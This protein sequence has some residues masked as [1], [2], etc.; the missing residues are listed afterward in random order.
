MT[1]FSRSRIDQTTGSGETVTAVAPVIVSASR[2]T[3]IPAFHAEWFMDRL[4]AGY[5]VW[6]NPFNQ[7]PQYVSFANTRVIV[8]WTK[9]PAPLLPYLPRIE[10]LGLNSYFQY[11]VNDYESEGWEP[12]VPSLAKRLDTFAELSERIGPERVIWRFDPLLLTDRVTEQVLA[13]KVARVGERLAPLTSKLVFS[14][15]DIV[16]YRKVRSNLA[17]AEIPYRE[18][19]PEIMHSLAGRIAGLCRSWNIEAA[20]CGEKIDLSDLGIARNRCIDGDLMRR[21]FPHDR[22]LQRFLTPKTSQGMMSMP[23]INP[24]WQD[25]LK[26]KGQRRECG[27][28]VSKDI[29]AYNTCLHLCTYCYANTSEAAV[30]NNLTNK[31]IGSEGI[32]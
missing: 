12:N 32:V 15:A 2:S 14:F 3:D 11:T 25:R 24:A 29:G 13:D 7:R 20:T 28:I 17:K 8:F 27:C 19:T 10:E 16:G 18:F 5:A 4:K 21:A 9:N 6:K 31:Q 23:G 30:R 1:V 22:A 26:D